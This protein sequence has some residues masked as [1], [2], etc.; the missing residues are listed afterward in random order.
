[1]TIR[2]LTHPIPNTGF[3]QAPHIVARRIMDVENMRP[4][5]LVKMANCPCSCD[6]LYRFIHGKVKLCNALAEFFGEVFR[7]YLNM[8]GW[9]NL[10]R[11]HALYLKRSKR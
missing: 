8:A 2:S 11:E 7:G 5:R 6:Y 3:V 10:R 4:Y 1:M 9:Q